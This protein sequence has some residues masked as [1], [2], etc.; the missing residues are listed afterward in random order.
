MKSAFPRLQ[1]TCCKLPVC[2]DLWENG[3]ESGSDP[4]PMAPS[5]LRVE[6]WTAL[7]LRNLLLNLSLSIHF[8]EAPQSSTITVNLRQ[9]PTGIPMIHTTC[10]FSIPQVEHSYQTVLISC[11]CLPQSLPSSMSGYIPVYP[12][13]TF[14]HE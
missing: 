6:S 12:T 2:V 7:S 1:V 3:S 8:S 4:F 9:F 11:Q 10:T 14:T 5:D 13:T